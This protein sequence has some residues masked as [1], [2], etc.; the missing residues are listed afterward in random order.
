MRVRFRLRCPIF[1]FFVSVFAPCLDPLIF[2]C[3]PCLVPMVLQIPFFKII[4][5]CGL[6]PVVRGV[7]IKPALQFRH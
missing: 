4:L 7:R 6:V 2:V 1:R 5:E 3:F